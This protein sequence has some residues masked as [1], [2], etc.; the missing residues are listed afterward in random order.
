M[1][2]VIGLLGFLSL[3]RGYEDAVSKQR[4]AQVSDEIDS[5]QAEIESVAD[6]SQEET[7]TSIQ[8]HRGKDPAE[9]AR[10]KKLQKAVELAR[11]KAFDSIGKLTLMKA[12]DDP[13]YEP[14]NVVA[15]EGGSRRHQKHATATHLDS[16]VERTR[17]SK[18]HE[19]TASTASNHAKSAA[20]Q[21]AATPEIHKAD[22]SKHGKV[23]SAP[24]TTVHPALLPASVAKRPDEGVPIAP[25][26][27]AAVDTIEEQHESAA[28]FESLLFMCVSLAAVFALWRYSGPDSDCNVTKSATKSTTTPWFR[29]R[30]QCFGRRQS[31]KRTSKHVHFGNTE[32][33]E[34]SSGD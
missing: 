25:V 2:S 19:K 20:L 14:S 24:S 21:Q 8:K 26:S 18:M 15:S 29:E 5:A 11:N 30:F 32:T 4:A 12:H 7:N 22:V 3:S 28:S 34:I 9:A 13:A 10:E 17:S 31:V 6:L 23:E 27:N 33:K 16:A 1:S